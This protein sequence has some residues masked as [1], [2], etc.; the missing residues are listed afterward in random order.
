M[1]KWTHNNCVILIFPPSLGH[2]M[3]YGFRC[4][5]VGQYN[6]STSGYS[7]NCC[8]Y[9]CRWWCKL[10]APAQRHLCGKGCVA[11]SSRRGDQR[12]ENMLYNK[13]FV[14]IGVTQVD[15]YILRSCMISGKHSMVG[16]FGI[17]SQRVLTIV[18]NKQ[19]ALVQ[20]VPSH[21]ATSAVTK[22]RD[23]PRTTCGGCCACRWSG[24]YGWGGSCML[25]CLLMWF[26]CGWRRESRCWT[27][28]R[29]STCKSV[30]ICHRA[31]SLYLT[32][33]FARQLK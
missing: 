29:L 19:S 27:G 3:W 13:T 23:I 12:T 4:L 7:P 32:F 6:F 21:V 33:S 1:G 8:S 28:R 11:D 17:T 15:M 30:R 26:R 20:A 14:P 31:T 18:T 25:S 10:T 22:T 5:R 9:H 16:F 24:A 2:W